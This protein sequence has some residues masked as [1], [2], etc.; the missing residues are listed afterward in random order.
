[1]T[2]EEIPQMQ[3]VDA[4]KRRVTIT[5]SYVDPAGLIFP[6]NWKKSPYEPAIQARIVWDAQNYY[7]GYGATKEEARAN[8]IEFARKKLAP[9]PPPEEVEI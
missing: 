9:P 3:L 6:A 8:V 7:V 5:Y 2:K 1:M 4:G